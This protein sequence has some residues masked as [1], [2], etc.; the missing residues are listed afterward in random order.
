MLTPKQEAFAQQYLTLGNASEAYR[1][2]YPRSVHW[3][4]AVVNC[5]ASLLLHHGE[6]M[7]RLG[8]LRTVDVGAAVMEYREA[9]EAASAVARSVDL[10]PRDRLAAIALLGKLKGWDAPSRMDVTSGGEPIQRTEIVIVPVSQ[11]HYNRRNQ[12]PQGRG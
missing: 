4:P 3:K 12:L 1:V 5:K 10:P 7:V 11:D 8:E 9:L 6:V 2:A